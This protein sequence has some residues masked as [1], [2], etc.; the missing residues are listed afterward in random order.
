MNRWARTHSYIASIEVL[1]KIE[2]RDG[3]QDNEVQFP[4]V[5]FLRSDPIWVFEILNFFLDLGGSIIA[6]IV[7]VFQRELVLELSNFD[8]F[9]HGAS[10]C[11]TGGAILPRK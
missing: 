6:R 1:E 10:S 4:Q 7:G 11:E 3:R 9:A 8:V 5:L 2:R